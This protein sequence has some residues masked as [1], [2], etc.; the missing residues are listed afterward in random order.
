MDDLVQD[1]Y[2]TIEPLSNG[3]PIDI[4]EEQIDD[5]GESI[6]EVMRSWANPTKRDSTFSIR[7][8]KNF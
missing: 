6:K 1:I 4:T 5:F 2:K 3:E 8:F 7:M